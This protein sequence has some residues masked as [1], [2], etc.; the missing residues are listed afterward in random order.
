MSQSDLTTAARLEYLK[1]DQETRGLLRD[2][3]PVLDG[4]LQSILD[5]FYEHI[6]QWP[7]LKTLVGDEKKIGMLK[8][9]QKQ[10]WNTLFSGQFDEDYF[11]RSTLI[12]QAHERIGLLPRW[13]MG[14]Y[15]FTLMRITEILAKQYRKKPEQMVKVMQAVLKAVFLDM[16]LAVTVYIDAGAENVAKETQKLADLLEKE[17][18]S[19]VEAVSHNSD[20]LRA[21]AEKVNGAIQRV[22]QSS[23]AV[24][25]ASEQASA[26]VET[27]AA[28]SEE[29]ASSVGEVGRQMRQSQ[30]ITVKAVDEATRTSEVVAGLAE[31]ANEIGEIVKLISDIAAQ[32]NL[33]ALNAT[34]EAARAGEA[35][36]GFAVVAAEV[37]SLAN[38]TGKATE[39]ISNQ[40][41]GIQEATQNAVAAI[42]NISDVIGDIETISATIVHAV[43]QQGEATSEIS[44]NVQEA[45]VGTQDVSTNIVK[46]AEESSNVG[47]MA[48]GMQNVSQEMSKSVQELTRRVQEILDRLRNRRSGERRQVPPRIEPIRQ[49]NASIN[50]HGRW[51]DVPLFQI[52]P[53]GAMINEEVEARTGERIQIRGKFLDTA[54][55]AVV[56]G[57][58]DGKTRLRFEINDAQ[59]EKIIGYIIDYHHSKAA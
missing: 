31:R 49:Q 11:R 5:A 51:Q 46:V 14:G 10:H 48:T 55:E 15:L 58:S 45:A 26:N 3:L 23:T 54:I 50:L 44:R 42:K 53:G 35:G 40:V 32:T 57:H 7:D 33:L 56:E 29:L 6:T 20:E 39:Q 19:A 27:V 12:G 38:E 17:V 25:S 52:G 21:S 41:T 24:A 36:K 28:A 8:G 18:H 1:I 4:N 16:D 9:A 22:S 59:K 37:K 34:I 43:E 30:D 2:F 13:Y 47:T